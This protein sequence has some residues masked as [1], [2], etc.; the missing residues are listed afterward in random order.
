MCVCLCNS[1]LLYVKRIRVYCT[2]ACIF[3]REGARETAGVLRDA[4][5][6]CV[7]N[8]SSPCFKIVDFDWGD[9]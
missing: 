6:L 9:L 5:T 4:L 2:L 3:P 1:V 7:C 8:E